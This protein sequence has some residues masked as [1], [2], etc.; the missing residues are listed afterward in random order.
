MGQ[1]Y[2]AV[3]L[4]EKNKPLASVSSYDFGSGAK[5]M[6]HSWAKNP[7]KFVMYI[8]IS[9]FIILLYKN[10]FIKKVSN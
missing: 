1:Y 3:F 5:L 4:T 7:L 10:K 9:T 2:K 8:S 6:E